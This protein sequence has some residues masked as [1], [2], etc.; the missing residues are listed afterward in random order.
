MPRPEA[1][2]KQIKYRVLAVGNH[3]EFKEPVKFV[4][5]LNGHIIQCKILSLV[6]RFHMAVKP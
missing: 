1:E 5:G 6:C 4:S 3:A 2:H